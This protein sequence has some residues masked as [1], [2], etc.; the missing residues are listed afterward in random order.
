MA[1][2]ITFTNPVYLWALILV[3]LLILLSYLSNKYSKS[4]TLKFAN[5]IALSRVSGGIKETTNFPIL[6]IRM[7]ALTCVILAISGMTLWYTG[8]TSNKDYVLAIDG[9]AS[10]LNTDFEP[11]RLDA[12]KLAAVNFVDNLP[13]SANVGVLSFAGTSFVEQPL[14]QEKDVI[15]AAILNI[16]AK[17]IG[18]TDF[19]N[20]ILTATNLLIPSKK[21][22]NIILLTDG[23]SNIGISSETAIA[24]AI[25]NHIVVD[26]IGIGSQEAKKDELDLG[27]DEEAL[28][29]IAFLTLGDYYHV[30]TT[31]DLNNVY[32]NLINT[33]T[34]GKNPVDLTFILLLIA[35]ALFISDWL[36]GQTIYRRI[37]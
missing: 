8:E 28:K 10:M 27:V 32:S 1:I 25:D 2:D 34:I 13:M 15:K 19:G 14:T 36:M 3:P 21:S 17:S 5:F 30:E 4:L 35:L 9:S 37:P 23:R 22:R 20:A 6:F 33:E 7:V 11:T 18:G 16:E 24:Y 29:E 12:A 31:E 26:T